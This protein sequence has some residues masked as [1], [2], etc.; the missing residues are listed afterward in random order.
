VNG[1]DPLH[2]VGLGVSEDDAEDASGHGEL[3]HITLK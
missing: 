1:H 2:V 3:M